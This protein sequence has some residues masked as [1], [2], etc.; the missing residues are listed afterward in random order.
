MPFYNFLSDEE[1]KLLHDEAEGSH[2][3]TLADWPAIGHT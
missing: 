1:R 2:G 3:V